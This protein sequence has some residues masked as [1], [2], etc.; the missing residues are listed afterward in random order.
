MASRRPLVNV[1]GSIRELPTGDTLPGVRELLTAA[2]TYYVRTDGS[3]S[4]T[5]LSNT[6]GG[7]FLTI[8]KAVDTVANL[9]IGIQQVIVQ[10]ADGT[11]A[12]GIGVQLRTLVG[13]GMCRIVGNATTPANVIIESSGAMAQTDGN[14]QAAGI[15]GAWQIESM[16]LRSTATGS[17]TGL[18]ASAG[19]LLRFRAVDFGAGLMFHLRALDSGVIRS[20]GNY[21]ISGGASAH[22]ISG[23]GSSLR[24]E[25]ITV[26][27]TGSP[28]FTSAFGIANTNGTAIF[29]SVTFT[30]SATGSRY[31]VGSSGVMNTNG[32]G[33]T[34]LPGDAA[35]TNDGTGVYL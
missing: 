18:S 5:G 14:F 3:D 4:N 10:I 15:S 20:T 17:P 1:S 11:Y 7:A 35:G 22:A 28:A 31:N 2:R 16:R 8:Q 13:S 12:V 29:A 34:Y 33:A 24:I 23:Q 9:D 27:L 32:A 21:S 26:T 19:S 6:A 30:G 25:S